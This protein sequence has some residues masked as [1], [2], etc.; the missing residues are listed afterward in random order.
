M[1]KRKFSFFQVID[2]MCFYETIDENINVKY[3]SVQQ[4]LD[5]MNHLDLYFV[6]F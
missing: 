1:N 4:K 2:L 5:I 6:N 3:F